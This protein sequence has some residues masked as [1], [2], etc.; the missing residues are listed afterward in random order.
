MWIINNRKIFYSISAVL[1][2]ASLL[3]LL[4]WGLK[5]GID[6]RGGSLLEVNYAATT[7]PTV[8]ALNSAL[9]PLSLGDVSVRPTGETG[10]LVRTHALTEIEREA[11]VSSLVRVDSS[12]TVIRFDSIGPVLGKEA[13]GR[14]FLSIGMVLIAI[15]AFIAFAFRKVSL[16]VAS[17][18]YGLI[19]VVALFHDVIIPTGVF[20]VLGQLYGVEVD[21]LFVTALLVILGFSIHDTIVVFDRTRE[22]LRHENEKRVRRPFS[23]IVGQ[24]VSETVVR[25][26]NTSLTTLFALVVL[27]IF[28]PSSTQMFSLALLIGVT[29]GTYSSIFIAST[30]LVTIEGWQ[31]KGGE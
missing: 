27:T 1:V 4:V 2:G 12:M 21:T 29:V 7:T 22:N 13:A 15:V 19:A 6:F 24:S 17:W 31:K 3:A 9:S 30:L 20:A 11:V 8:A 10:Y 5:P 14:A 18:K 16:P 25:S 26:I 28:G 23:E